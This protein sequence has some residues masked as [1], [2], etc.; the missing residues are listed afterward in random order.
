VTRPPG[1]FDDAVVV[2]WSAAAS[3][4]KGADS[5]WLAAGSLLSDGPI[6]TENLATRALASARIDALVDRS[7]QRGRRVLVAVDVSFGLPA[8][9][10]KV[11]GLS[12]RPG[13]RALWQTLAARLIDGDDNGNNRFA[14]ADALNAEAGVRCFWGRPVAPAFEVYQHLPIKD[15]PVAGLSA[16]PLPR[17]RRCELLAGPGV[18]SNWMLVG[19]GAVG[20]QMLTCLPRLER[21]RARLGPQLAVWPFAGLA[22][23]GHDVVLAECWHGLFDWRAERD[24]VRDQA[25]VRGT[26]RAL[27]RAGVEGRAALL[28]P[29]AALALNRR[30]QREIIGEEGW[31]LGVS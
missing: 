11:L 15:Q 16:N 14:V 29:S 8:G 1:D 5:C 30:A 18:I 31:T 19:K 7:L 25:Q 9:A 27:R 21:L 17:L 3:P 4:S 23:P 24:R 6:R 12:G 22:D 2:D 26:L 10:A 13:W 20:G 28:A